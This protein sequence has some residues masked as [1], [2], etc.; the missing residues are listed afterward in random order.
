[1]RYDHPVETVRVDMDE[2]LLARLDRQ[3]EVRDRGR[4]AVLCEAVAEYLARHEALPPAGERLPL[5]QWLLKHAPRGANLPIPD[6]R[7]ADRPIPFIDY[8]IPFDNCDED[9]P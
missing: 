8:D 9:G 6:R 1:M 7:E 2:A 3:P 4:S 5:G